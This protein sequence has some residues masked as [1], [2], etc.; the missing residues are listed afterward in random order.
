MTQ[1]LLGLIYV[2]IGLASDALTISLYFYLTSKNTIFIIFA[3]VVAIL[4]L[5]SLIPIVVGLAAIV[6]PFKVIWI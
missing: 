6:L 4:L 3:P 5:A 1:L 2:L